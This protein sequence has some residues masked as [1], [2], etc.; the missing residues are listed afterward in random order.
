MKAD[1]VIETP[2]LAE[3]LEPERPPYWD[4]MRCS[5]CGN[6]IGRVYLTVGSA[7]ELRC[8]HSIVRKSDGKRV[9]CGWINTVRPTR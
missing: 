2:A 3:R 9:T 8:H 5:R 1:Y 7:V 6:P 4:V